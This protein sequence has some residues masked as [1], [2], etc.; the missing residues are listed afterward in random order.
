MS[1]AQYTEGLLLIGR[2]HGKSASASGQ[3]PR[4]GLD[5]ITS[6][7]RRQSDLRAISRDFRDVPIS[8]IALYSINSSA[9]AIIVG[10]NSTPSALATLRSN[11]SSNLVGCSTGISDGFAPL[12]IL[13]T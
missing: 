6:V 11:R 5:T 7:L 13:S 10:G 3:T 1:A 12:R 9:L 2:P 4:P 8:D